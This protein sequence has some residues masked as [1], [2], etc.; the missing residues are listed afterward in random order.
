MVARVYT[1]EQ[2]YHV[3]A[4]AAIR[5]AASIDSEEDLEV[6][7]Y[8]HEKQGHRIHAALLRVMWLREYGPR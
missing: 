8:L 2:E 7:V 1:A 6:V 5:E 3:R 4:A